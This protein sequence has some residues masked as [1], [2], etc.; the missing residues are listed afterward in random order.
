LG[1]QS[2]TPEVIFYIVSSTKAILME[3]YDGS[4][5]GQTNPTISVGEQ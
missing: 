2:A 3:G 1:D 5:T 4:G